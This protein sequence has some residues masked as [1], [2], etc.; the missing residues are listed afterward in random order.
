[1]SLDNN[2]NKEIFMKE[3]KGLWGYSDEVDTKLE[4]LVKEFGNQMQREAIVDYVS[5]IDVFADVFNYYYHS[6]NEEVLIKPERLINIILSWEDYNVFCDETRSL[7]NNCIVKEDDNSTYMAI[8]IFDTSK[9]TAKIIADLLIVKIMYCRLYM[10]STKFKPL[11]TLFVNWTKD[12]LVIDDK[13]S[14]QLECFSQYD[15]DCNIDILNI[16]SE[17]FEDLLR[18]TKSLYKLCSVIIKDMNC[19]D[20]DFFDKVFKESVKSDDTDYSAVIDALYSGFSGGFLK[21]SVVC[22]EKTDCIFN[23][24]IVSKLLENNVS[25]DIITYATGITEETYNEIKS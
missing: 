21:G 8:N 16:Q 1:M 18:L 25:W 15:L 13:I 2:V 9:V 5:R 6:S 4:D 10:N 7:F 20:V 12:E 19:I 22:L 14:K 24:N 23:H 3:F 17:K 11:V